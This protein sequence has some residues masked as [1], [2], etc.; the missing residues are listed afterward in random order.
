[1]ARNFVILLAL[2]KASKIIVF[3]RFANFVI[4]HALSKARIIILLKQFARI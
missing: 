1:M 2:G 4:L 3:K